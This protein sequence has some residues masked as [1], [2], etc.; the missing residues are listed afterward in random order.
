MFL[1]FV[2]FIF[3]FFSE[4]Y[5]KFK[6]F[7]SSSHGVALYTFCIYSLYMQKYMILYMVA[8]ALYIVY[9]T[10]VMILHVVS[11]DDSARAESSDIYPFFSVFLRAHT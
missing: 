11:R 10:L 4:R 7:S 9:S 3:Y 5:R 8:T 6:H 2:I 1:E